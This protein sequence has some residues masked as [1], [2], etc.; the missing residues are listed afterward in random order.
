MAP[1]WDPKPAPATP[2]DQPPNATC[3]AEGGNDNAEQNPLGQRQTLRSPNVYTNLGTAARIAR[4]PAKNSGKQ[5]ENDKNIVDECEKAGEKSQNSPECRT[6]AKR[7]QWKT[8]GDHRETHGKRDGPWEACK[9]RPM[10]KPNEKNIKCGASSQRATKTLLKKIGNKQ[11]PT[12]PEK[13]RKNTEKL[14]AVC[15]FAFKNPA[16]STDVA[17]IGPN[18]QYRAPA[19]AGI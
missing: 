10:Q 13:I 5:I 11:V 3:G 17:N 4:K 7:N 19:K 14:F 16:D 15:F 1:L 9:I 18:H 2:L 8:T 12:P 6:R